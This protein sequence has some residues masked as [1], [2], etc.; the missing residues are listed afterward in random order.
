MRIA[1]TLLIWLIMVGGLSL[2]IQ[3]R[4]RRMP[5][6]VAA[7]TMEA[8][9]AEEYTLEITPTFSPEPDPFAIGGDQAASSLVV[10]LGERVLL[11]SSQALPAGRPVTV[12]PL[13]GLAVGHNELYLQVSPPVGEAPMDH[14][15]RVRLL[16]GNR[17]IFDDTVWGVNGA[18]VA[19]SIPFTLGK[20]AEGAHGH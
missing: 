20:P 8:A 7:P 1:L 3:Q 10:R 9:P 13:E 19:G 5:A 6:A 4:D 17:E 12:H 11:R 15:V 2:Y 16:Q 18:T 14:A